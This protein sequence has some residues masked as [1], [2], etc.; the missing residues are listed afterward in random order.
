MLLPPYGIFLPN[1]RDFELQIRTLVTYL[2][3]QKKYVYQ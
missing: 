1:S 2:K 3:I